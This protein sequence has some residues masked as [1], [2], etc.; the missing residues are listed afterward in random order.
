MDS[1]TMPTTTTARQAPGPETLLQRLAA[2]RR[3]LR[4][5]TAC[6]G[7]GWLLT[8]LLAPAIAAGVLDWRFHLPA[9]VRALLLIGTLFTAGVVALRYLLR[10]FAS[11][12]DDLSLALRVEERFP[13]FNDALASTVQFLIGARS[14]APA[15]SESLRR[16][17]IQRTIGRAQGIDFNRVVDS[18]G[19]RAALLSAGMALA[20]IVA[21]ISLQPALAATALARFANPFGPRQWPH[22]TQI[23]V[24]TP[25]ERIGRNEAFEVRAHIRGIIPD[26]ASA[27]F[28]TD[29]LSPLSLTADV[30]KEGTN[31][32]RLIVRLPPD[33]VQRTF[34]FHVQANDAESDEYSVTVLPP[35]LLVPLA[36]DEPSPHVQLFFPRYTDL[37]S[38]ALLPAGTGNIEA[39]VGTAVRLRA[40]ADRVLR[41]AAV[42]FLPE[43]KFIAPSLFLAALGA[44]SALSAV[45]A[46]TGSESV[47]RPVPAVFDADQRTFTIDFLPRVAGMYALNFEDESGL[48]ASRLFE[49]RLRP[50][51]APTVQLERPSPARDLLSVLPEAT[52]TLHAIAEDPVFAVRNVYLEYRIGRQGS[53]MRRMLYEPTTLTD[54]VGPVLGPG[55]RAAGLRPRPQ[56]IEINQ[57]LPLYQ[58]THADGTP[59]REN[60]V[61]LLTVCAD[62]FDDVAFDKQ[63]GRSHE[64]EIRIVA[65]EAL[66]IAI[67]QEQTRLQ[68]DLLR[69]REKQREAMTKTASVENDLK[70]GSRFGPDQLEQLLQAQQSQQ[71]VREQI[72]TDKEG[73]RS[74]AERVLETLKQ[75]KLENS[76]ER[77][78]AGDVARELDRL[79][80]ENL[81]Q[82][83]A[84][85]ATARTR[86][87][88]QEDKDNPERGDRAEARARE[89][90]RQAHAAEEAARDKS[91]E[92]AKAEEAANKA[93]DPQEKVRLLKEAERAKQQAESQ[94]KKAKELRK[95]ATKDR[96]DAAEP[97]PPREALADAHRNQ[98]EIEKTLSDLL[99]KMEPWTNSREIKGEAGRLLQEQQKLQT[100]VEQL[101]KDIP[102]G[103]SPD[104]LTDSQKADLESLSDAQKQQEV[105]TNQLLEKMRR[106]AEDR[107]EKD[108]QGSRELQD[109]SD[110]AR[111]SNITGQMKDAAEQVKQNKL[112]EANNSQ[113]AS[114]ASLKQLL[115][116][117]EEHREPELDRLTKKSRE[118]EKELD[119]LF[120][121]QDRLKKKM[122]DAEGIADPKQREE[123]LQ[124]LQREQ[125]EL[126]K[127]AQDL[128]QRLTKD[129]TAGRA[130][131]SLAKAG[132]KMEQAAQQLSR[133]EKADESMEEALDRLDEARAEAEQSTD[134]VENELEREQRARVADTLKRLKERQEAFNAEATRVQTKMQGTLTRNERQILR[135]SL[136]DLIANQKALGRE[137]SEVGKKELNAVPVFSRLVQRSAEAM[138]EA[139]NRLEE[140][141]KDPPAPETLPDAQVTRLQALAVRRLS[142]VMTSL[143]DENG[144]GRL[145][146]GEG[147]AGGGGGGAGGGGGDDSLP[148][149][150]QLKVL[151]KLQEDVNHRTE[152]FARD[153]A[154]P[155]TIDD[156]AK[157]EL[158]EILSDQKDVAE[159]LEQLR[160]G[161]EPN[162]VEGA[163]P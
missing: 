46:L 93:S 23:E 32:G 125:K 42:E 37:P 1:G 53:P 10:P 55:I 45:T 3:R 118:A 57:P 76:P 79:A 91:A 51:P 162:A 31:A 161:N 38:P 56:R 13:G 90:E 119:Q 25:R 121:D 65:R 71:Q 4:V 60:D 101:N 131:Q 130:G 160:G 105:R 158:K 50:D 39:V 149:T 150:A 22:Q 126:Q 64:V 33:R 96:H 138:D 112:G 78:R 48:G 24:E 92:A 87:E 59:P 34:H 88:L 106:V 155:K 84:Q 26:Q 85:L 154:D 69:L 8:V 11:R 156:K 151:R 73:L 141:Q 144:A 61:I 14:E 100:T 15:D 62:D 157:A 122:K 133:G 147:G 110:R 40:R 148:P 9:L 29:G 49:L 83:E 52:L 81:E 36:A 108:P 143:K 114:V 116:D 159:L 127:K 124:K 74:R 70:K 86:A 123:T 129:R 120:Q 27:I 137:V 103:K 63:P 98:E 153:H 80:A 2:L 117:L 41:R 21:L 139:S 28:L 30:A 135:T 72:G 47:W 43:D 18:R 115:K 35:P 77:A 134:R 54:V 132:E 99:Q 68:Q 145:S 95:E 67:N 66:D 20:A 12:T 58:L 5:V 94:Q 17:A 97:P 152:A 111:E 44:N 163:K 6:R 140:M 75:N 136:S 7:S 146:R 19:L 82:A 109:A 107:K 128:V 113:K 102:P 142:Q 104:E 89:A 16:V